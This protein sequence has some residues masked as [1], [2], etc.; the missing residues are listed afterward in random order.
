MGVVYKATDTRLDRTV[1]LKF[2]PENISSGSDEL[3]RF[4]QEAKA[5]AA[6]NHPNICTIYGIEQADTKHFIVMEF[7]EG[8]T[9]QEKKSSL[10]M[11]QALD[12]GIQIA[13]GLAAAHEKGIVHRDI[14]PEN[15]MFRKDGRV[16]IMDFGLAKLRGTSRLTKEGS[17]VGTA[18]Y[19]SPEQVQGQDTD[20]RSDI[21]SLGVLMYEM[22]TGQPPFKGLH[23]TAVAYEIVNLDSAPMSSL[24]PEIAPEL[25]AVVLECLEKDPRERTQSASQVAVDLKRCRRESSRSRASKSIQAYPSGPHAAP[26]AEEERR[27]AILRSSRPIVWQILAVILLLSTTT[28]AYLH[29]SSSR[30]PDSQVIRLT[31]DPP[32]GATGLIRNSFVNGAPVVSPDGRYVAFSAWK[33]EGSVL[34]IRALDRFRTVEVSIDGRRPFFSPDGAWLGFL[35][36]EAT[37]WKVRSEGGEPVRVGDVPEAKWNIV[38]EGWH[39]DG[40]IFVAGGVGL[41]TLPSTGGEPTLLTK[42]D[43]SLQEVYTG[44]TVS[45]EGH[46]LLM[47]RRPERLAESGKIAVMLLSSDGQTLTNLP[48]SIEPPVYIVDELLIFSQSGQ[49][50]AGSFDLSSTTIRGNPVSITGLPR[51]SDYRF[52]EYPVSMGR[53]AAWMNQELWNVEP[54]WVTSSG[55]ATPI[56]LAA[57]DYRWP[58]LSPDGRR[59][60]V[61]P[62]DGNL[63]V[64]DLRS[65]SRVLLGNNSEH[66]E[67]VWSP[68]GKYIVFSCLGTG[69]DAGLRGLLRQVSDASQQAD[70]LLVPTMRDAWPSSYSPDGRYVAFYGSKSTADLDL[71][72]IDV[73]TKEV[74]QFRAMGA[75]RAGRF[76]PNGRW[77]AYQSDESGRFEVY[78]RPW[79]SMATKS[80]ISVDGGTEPVWSHDG[81]ELYFRKSTGI[82]AVQVF[83]ESAFR[84]SQPRELFHGP[85]P[86]DQWGDQSYDVAPD[87]RFLMLRSVDETQMK[88]LVVLNWIEEIKKAIKTQGQ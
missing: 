23:E 73:Q 44:L 59:L 49:L 52:R 63:Y 33:G 65:R 75:Q 12:V 8:Q 88:V 61:K 72:V 24:K 76:S 21:F 29:F 26:G 77:L 82:M 20:H 4:V 22:L 7:V 1:A 41:W 53:S 66:T 45:P 16:Q 10:S 39:P 43:T 50:R 83:Q 11:K 81:R 70:T 56:G 25:D 18:G 58:R 48:S 69:A 74:R 17:T 35:S 5:A 42:P 64:L 13:E 31:V 67:P 37:V 46:T 27:P 60:A 79:P 30:I 38:G 40:R 28:V 15:I 14:K 85:Y 68:D 2:L 55:L 19:M 34:F 62:L 54:V 57:E 71:F 78:V 6:L 47:V 84:A 36:N 9:L 87:G 80:P 51:M 86:P 3:E 32:E